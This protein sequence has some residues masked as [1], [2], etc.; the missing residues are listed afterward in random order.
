MT[1]VLVV[2][3]ESLIRM[4]IAD[5]LEENGFT[6]IEAADANQALEQLER[7]PSITIVFTDVNM[8]G[9]IDGI[10]LAKAVRDRWPPVRIYVTSGHRRV[11][12]S[13]LPNEAVFIPKPYNPDSLIDRFRSQG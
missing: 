12:E 11:D 9:S 5:S 10:R 8:P 1:T 3:D 4:A 6:V 2:E 7:H 13:E